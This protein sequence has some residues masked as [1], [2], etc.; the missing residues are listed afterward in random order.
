VDYDNLV[1]RIRRK[2]M[3]TNTVI[4][5]L[6]HCKTDNYKVNPE[7]ISSIIGQSE[8][9]NKLEFFVKSHSA[10]TPMPTLLFAGSQGLGKSYTAQRVAKAL[11]RELIELNCSMYEDADEFISE[12]LLKNILGETPKTILFDES[13]K[14]SPAIT[15]L[16]LTLLNPNKDNKNYLQYNDWIIEYDLNLINAIFATTDTHKMA[17]PLINRCDPIY[18]S[19]Y[20][21]ADLINI[22][23]SYTNGINLSCNLEDLAKA[24]RGRARDAFMIAQNVRR[25]CL[26]KSINVFDDKAWVDMKHIFGIQKEGLK[27]QEITLLR[28]ISDYG[29][30]SGRNLANKMGLNLNNIEGEL[31]PILR[32]LGYIDNSSLGRSLTNKGKQYLEDFENVLEVV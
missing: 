4:I 3:N 17:K 25:Y 8:V 2:A 10:Q 1:S 24:C 27:T 15:T 19:L 21:N 32:V 26:I 20:S 30:I 23:K 5:P 28:V 13:H 11:N 22:V 18:F 6:I 29:P 16:L 9:C 12:F 7:H 14:L 31:E